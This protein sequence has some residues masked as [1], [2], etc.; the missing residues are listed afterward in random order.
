[1]LTKISLNMVSTFYELLAI[2]VSKKISLHIARSRGNRH[3]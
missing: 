3:N 2:H 1:M